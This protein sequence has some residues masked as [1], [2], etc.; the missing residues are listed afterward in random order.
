MRMS[1]EISCSEN[2]ERQLPVHSP[3]SLNTPLNLL[4]VSASNPFWI[5]HSNTSSTT[6][7]LGSY[8]K[9][10]PLAFPGPSVLSGGL[11]SA[12]RGARSNLELERDWFADGSD[13]GGEVA[14]SVTALRGAGAGGLGEKE[15]RRGAVAVSG[16]TIGVV[17]AGG[18]GS[19]GG[20][21]IGRAYV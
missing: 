9:S 21:E 17:E 13:A 20:R 5:P 16:K 7:V 12:V 19:E 18:E 14:C 10:F 1:P 15:A 8:G 3:S 6:H 11:V 2:R 4:S